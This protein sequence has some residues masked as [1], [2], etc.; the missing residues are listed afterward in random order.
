MS[1]FEQLRGELE[2]ISREAVERQATRDA[3]WKAYLEELEQERARILANAKREQDRKLQI[4]KNWTKAKEH[5]LATFNQ[6]S[7]QALG[8]KGRIIDWEKKKIIFTWQEDYSTNVEDGDVVKTVRKTRYH[9]DEASCEIAALEIK[10]QGLVFVLRRAI[11]GNFEGVEVANVGYYCSSSV[12]SKLEHYTR[13]AVNFCQEEAAAS[14]DFETK[15]V[16]S[17]KRLFGEPEPSK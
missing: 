13:P 16:N 9:E 12:P 8:G 14:R 11:G 6:I 17:L 3:S 4:E 2:K 5:I 7:E 15:I 1:R 10:P